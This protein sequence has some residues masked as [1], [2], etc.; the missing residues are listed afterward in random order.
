ML[1]VWRGA[2]V[3]ALAV[4]GVTLVAPAGA[5]RALD[6]PVP[7]PVTVPSSVV[8]G[9]LDSATAAQRAA[10]I[11][12]TSTTAVAAGGQLRLPVS[13]AA[14]FAK[15]VGGPTMVGATGFFLGFD[16]LNAAMKLAGVDPSIV[17]WEGL[18]PSTPEPGFIA[19]ADAIATAPGFKDGVDTFRARTGKSGYGYL[20]E[21]TVRVVPIDSP[22][23]TGGGPLR[24][25]LV[26][27]TAPVGAWGTSTL[28]YLNYTMAGKYANNTTCLGSTG[29]G[30]QNYPTSD[31]TATV[32]AGCTFSVVIS[33][34][35]A[36]GQVSTVTWYPVG[37]A[38][39]PPDVPA[40]PLRTWSTR[41]TCSGGVVTSD[42]APFSETASAWPEYPEAVCPDGAVP[43]LVE[44]WMIT[45]GAA[46]P[47][48][49]VRSWEPDPTVSDWLGAFP[50]CV[51][52]S[53]RLELYRQ[54]VTTGAQLSCMTNPSACVDW[55]QDPARADNYRCVYG[56]TVVDLAE[57]NVYGPTFN[58]ATGTDV[59]TTTGTRPAGTTG[60]Y[61]DPATGEPVPLP[62]GEPGTTP[63][64]DP[65]CPP[66]FNFSAGGIGYWI[67]KGVSCALAAA[68]VPSGQL[69]TAR[70]SEA[71]DGSVLGKLGDL[72]AGVG[73]AFEGLQDGSCG[74]I[75]DTSVE[76]MNGAGL[77]VSTCDFPWSSM[78]VLKTAIG[79]AFM[80]GAVLI[81]IRT[82]LRTIRVE[83]AGGSDGGK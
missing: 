24:F 69:Q 15:T 56:G 47:P 34:D 60:P 39:R 72:S 63:D 62:G 78:G 38:L 2:A 66:A 1:A 59:K 40:N 6:F 25:R 10:A 5:A 55:L 48:L 46:A 31:L 67:W 49:L 12:G 57:C 77:R 18:F 27:T 21:T 14:K 32:P 43:S 29:G 19:N 42:S 41:A 26:P 11:G 50:E 80:C 82:I 75:V 36:A 76:S 7:I 51:D 23:V 22:G 58:V 79:A 37:H 8:S 33:G 70:V 74:V 44:V 83:P 16:G 73:A 81:G 17:G 13:T 61:G 52:G 3:A 28:F 65:T 68:F 54:D 35:L 64:G 71:V 9:S 53:C 20:P 4:V 45:A 30:A